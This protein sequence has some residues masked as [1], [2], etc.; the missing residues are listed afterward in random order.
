MKIGAV[1]P[2]YRHTDALADV[3]SALRQ[4]SLPVIVVDDGN[5]PEQAAKISA[6]VHE[7]GDDVDLVVRPFNGG[8]GAAMKDGFRAGGRKSWTHIVQVDADGQHDLTQLPAMLNLANANQRRV[9]CATPVYDETIP[10]ARKIGREITHFWVRVETLSLE[11]NDSMCG[12]RV[13]PLADVLCVLDHEMI[14][15]RM[16]FDTEILVQ[17]N[18]R[19][20]R[21]VEHPTSVVYPEGNTSNFRML[22]DNI[23]ISAMHTR[24]ALQAVFRV[25]VRMFRRLRDPT[26]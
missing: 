22:Q 11:I 12:F 25:P 13:Y 18:W 20:L 24:L 21:I 8:K 19:G 16:D 17:L 4:Q 9:I 6:I 2:T 14:G 1:V 15:N 3:I 7:A 5:K 26:L 23:R 10:K